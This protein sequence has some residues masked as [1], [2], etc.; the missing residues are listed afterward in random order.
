MLELCCD[1]SNVTREQVIKFIE[2]KHNENFNG[3]YYEK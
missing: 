2:S 3:E 1:I